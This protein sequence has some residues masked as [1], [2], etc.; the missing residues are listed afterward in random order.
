MWV[1]RQTEPQLWTV[2]YYS[3]DG[4]WHSDSD[5]STRSEAAARARWLNGKGHE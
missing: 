5:H 2:G 1:Y 3:P 4:D